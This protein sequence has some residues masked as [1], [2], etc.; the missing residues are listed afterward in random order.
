MSIAPPSPERT[1]F[2]IRKGNLLYSHQSST[3]RIR[4]LAPLLL[5]VTLLLGASGWA[6]T[7]AAPVPSGEPADIGAVFRLVGE[8][9]QPL[10]MLWAA[11][12]QRSGLFAPIQSVLVLPG[13]RS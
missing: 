4:C 10:E 9:F 1:V 12:E 3:M 11:H 7:P 5:L 2:H 13:G 8:G 6:Q